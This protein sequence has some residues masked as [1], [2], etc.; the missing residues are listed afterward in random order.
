V[1]GSL[2]HISSVACSHFNPPF[3]SRTSK[4]DSEY[5]NALELYGNNPPNCAQL[6]RLGLPQS[7]TQTDD[8]NSISSF[9]RSDPARSGP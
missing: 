6:N 9:A 3:I 5:F 1:L 2:L 4:L 7:G 8:Q